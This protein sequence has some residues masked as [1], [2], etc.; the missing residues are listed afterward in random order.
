MQKIS[1]SKKF[2]TCV[3]A[4][5]VV[6]AFILRQCITW[7]RTLI[8]IEMVLIRWQTITWRSIGALPPTG[9]FLKAAYLRLVAQE[10]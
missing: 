8:P 7:L 5:L 9:Q 1:F 4:G 2:I 6:G 3:I 10:S